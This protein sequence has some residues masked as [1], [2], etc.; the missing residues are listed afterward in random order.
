MALI[1]QKFG[2]TSLAD[3]E[4][5]KSVAKRVAKTASGGNRVVVVLSAMAG[6]TNR[7]VDLAHRVSEFPDGRE[8][9]I[10]VSTGEQVTIGLLALALKGLKCEARSFLGDQVPIRTDSAHT[11]ARIEEIQTEKI[12]AELERGSV[13]VVAG[14]QGVDSMGDITTLGRG[15]SDTTAVALAAALKA[16]LCEISST[17][18][19][20]AYAPTPGSS[21][22]SRMTRCS[23]WRASGQ[24]CSRHA[25]SSSARSTISR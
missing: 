24:R 20:P 21:S 10:I 9:D 1:V 2:G 17:P 7:L 3:V 11:A 4:R 22:A 12:S 8:Y 13:V 16:D 18:P 25:L 15:G 6:E 23:R 5:I 14:F 19:T